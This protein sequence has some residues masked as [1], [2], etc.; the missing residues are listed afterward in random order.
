[1]TSNPFVTIFLFFEDDITSLLLKLRCWLNWAVLV[2][3]VQKR[4]R[5]AKKDS[6][7]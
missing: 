2:S 5:Y 7:L 6:D 3:W 4:S 1:M